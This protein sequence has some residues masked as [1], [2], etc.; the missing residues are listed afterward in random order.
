MTGRKIGMFAV[1]ALAFA[2][3]AVAIRPLLDHQ[4]PT[5]PP[6]NPTALAAPPTASAAAI[7]AAGRALAC[8]RPQQTTT[9]K[10]SA[11]VRVS[12][13]QLV[14]IRDEIACPDT[15]SCRVQ[16]IGVLRAA[17]TTVPVALT[18]DE[19]GGSGGWRVVA[20]SS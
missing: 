4:R 10:P 12:C 13:G 18:V 19:R 9:E 11:V 16:L 1:R 7:A 2:A 15:V 8:P 14:V 3:L 17:R 5:P 20:V 6:V